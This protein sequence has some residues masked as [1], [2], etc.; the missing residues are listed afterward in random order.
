MMD[1]T[2]ALLLTAVCL[3]GTALGLRFRVYVMVPAAVAVLI[4]SAAAQLLS[5][6]MVGWRIPS[7]LALLVILNVGFMLG[8]LLR[9][10][11]AHWYTRK[12]A[13]LFAP[14]A[15]VDPSTRRQD[16]VDREAN[17]DEAKSTSAIVRHDLAK[18][19]FRR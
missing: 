18:G 9:A 4:L 13:R 8:L 10:G 16:G 14:A 3:F 11:A 1:Q 7:W 6:K 19:G 15:R 2:V 5:N 17:S 12:I